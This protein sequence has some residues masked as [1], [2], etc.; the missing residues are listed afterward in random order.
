MWTSS[1]Q[2]QS[3]H[4]ITLRSQR[5]AD[6]LPST[7]YP[8]AYTQLSAGEQLL[9]H[10]WQKGIGQVMCH[11]TV[12]EEQEVR[13]HPHRLPGGLQESELALELRG[14]LISAM[15]WAPEVPHSPIIHLAVTKLSLHFGYSGIAATVSGHC[16]AD[17]AL[18]PIYQSHCVNSSSGSMVIW[19]EQPGES[20]QPQQHAQA[21]MHTAYL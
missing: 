2:N 8:Q 10:L 19:Y 6:L 16:V 3:I 14:Q 18:R 21:Y 12:Q 9:I 1:K 13:L 11:L 17:I 20:S 15:P 4:G 7:T 5:C